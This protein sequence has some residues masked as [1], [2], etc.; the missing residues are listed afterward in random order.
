MLQWLA[1]V[2][3]VSITACLKTTV[4]LPYLKHTISMQVSINAMLTTC[5]ALKYSLL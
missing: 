4:N 2:T 5:N 3:A 1:T